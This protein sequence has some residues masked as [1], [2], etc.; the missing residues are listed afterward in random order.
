[1]DAEMAEVAPGR[2]CDRGDVDAGAGRGRGDGP[3]EGAG[4]GRS[5]DRAGSSGCSPTTVRRYLAAGGWTPYRTPDRPSALAG[6]EDWLAE[7]FRRHRGNADVVRQ[8]LAARARAQG[9]PAHDRAG[10]VAACGASWRPRRGRRCASRRR[11]AISCRSTS[12]SC[13]CRSTARRGRVYPVRGDAGLLAAALCAGVPA[14]APV[15]LAGRDR[16]RVPALRRRARPRCWSTT[17]RRW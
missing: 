12:A 14:R 4:L 9:Q 6:L 1:M 7:R 16:G 10:G 3:A 11:R 17:P 13:G 5:T 8:D 15:G 2:G